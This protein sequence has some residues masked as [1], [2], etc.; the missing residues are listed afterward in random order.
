M[1]MEVLGIPPAS[2][3]EQGSRS[4]KFF[5]GFLPKLKPNSKGKLRRPGSKSVDLLL[6]DCEESDFIEFVKKFLVWN[7]SDRISAQEAML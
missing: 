3:V 2:L 4:N 7:P 5:D 1:I 6:G